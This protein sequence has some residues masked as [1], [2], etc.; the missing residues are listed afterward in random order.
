MVCQRSD[1]GSAGACWYI[2]DICS[3]VLRGGGYCYSD[4]KDHHEGKNIM[5][6]EPGI[7]SRTIIC[8]FER[9]GWSIPE[10]F[11]L[12]HKYVS[13]IFNFFLFSSLAAYLVLEQGPREGGSLALIERSEV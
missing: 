1:H 5:Y 11:N 7:K 4:V 9:R 2:T 6:C 10:G 13:F 12:E 8:G 3:S